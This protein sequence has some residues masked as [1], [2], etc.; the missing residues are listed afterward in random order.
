MTERRVFPTSIGAS[1]IELLSTLDNVLSQKAEDTLTKFAAVF[2]VAWMAANLQ[3]QLG[4]AK[5]KSPMLSGRLLIVN[6]PPSAGKS[7][8]FA[9]TTAKSANLRKIFR[10]VGFALKVAAD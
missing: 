6:R 9:K 1:Q 2:A 10:R 4:I 3:T 7:R 5:G 8:V